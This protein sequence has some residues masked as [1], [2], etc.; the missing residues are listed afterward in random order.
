MARKRRAAAAFES[1]LEPYETGLA[2]VLPPFV[3]QRLFAVGEVVIPLM[4]RLPDGYFDD[5]YAASRDPWQLA[6]R[7]YEQRKYAI[8]MA[9]L[10]DAR[11]GT[12]SSRA[13]RS[14]C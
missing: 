3:L 9:M 14:A 4:E 2:A 13:A 1:Q 7:W 5:I 11:T 6:D 10:P 12:P 8:T